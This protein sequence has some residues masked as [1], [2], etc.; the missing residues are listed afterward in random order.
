MSKWIE[1]SIEVHSI[2]QK[3]QLAGQKQSQVFNSRSGCMYAMHL[4]CCKAKLTNLKLKTRPQTTFLLSPVRYCAA[5][6][7][8]KVQTAFPIF[9]FH[10]RNIFPLIEDIFSAIFVNFR[11]LRKKIILTFFCINCHFLVSY[12]IC[13]TMNQN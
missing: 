6:F 13:T 3:L 8:C 7:N 9:S 4:F 2:I 10:F 5:Q 12:A 11:G 1:D